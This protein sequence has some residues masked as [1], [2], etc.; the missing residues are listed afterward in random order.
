MLTDLQDSCNTILSH[1]VVAIH[2]ETV[3]GLAANALSVGAVKKI[4][5]IK[6]RPHQNPLIVHILESKNAEEISYTNDFFYSL[7][8]RFW[9]GPLSLIL[10][11]NDKVPRITTGGMQTVAMRSPQSNIFRDVLRKTKLPLAAPSA[12][13]SNRISP[14]CADHVISGFKNNCPKILDGGNCSI[15]IESTVLDVSGRKPVILR[16]GPIGA[17]EIEDFLGVRIEQPS[18]PKR[19][20]KSPGLSPTHYSPIT[21]TIVYEDSSALIQ[22]IELNPNDIFIFPFENMISCS[23]IGSNIIPISKTNDSTEVS[24]K[25]YSVL[26]AADRAIPKNIRICLLPEINGLASALND[27]IRRTGKLIFKE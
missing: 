10:P 24:K 16:P 11:V 14:T 12:N 19:E 9:P 2:T 21:P 7:A 20:V 23:P 17:K 25:I 1:G 5:E 4:Y 8:E 27:R 6:G 22:E 13:P 15:G 3:Y 26:H 18:T